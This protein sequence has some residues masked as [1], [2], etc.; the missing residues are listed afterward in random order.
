MTADH[1]IAMCGQHCST[2]NASM[3]TDVFYSLFNTSA[4]P[5]LQA[6]DAD[7]ELNG[8]V[9]YF[10]ISNGQP[11]PFRISLTTGEVIVNDTLDRDNPLTQEFYVDVIARDRGLPP[12]E[13]LTT[14]L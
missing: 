5:V 12:L 10:F 14:T 6:K 7:I 13:V 2:N 1:T 11:L 3:S 4:F 9:T 8:Q